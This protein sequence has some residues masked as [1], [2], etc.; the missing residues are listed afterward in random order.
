MERAFD[1]V[2]IF[3]TLG[4]VLIE[5]TGGYFMDIRISLLAVVVLL[6]TLFGFLDLTPAKPVETN[7]PSQEVAVRAPVTSAATSGTQIELVSGG[8]T[9]PA[10][11]AEPGGAGP[12]PGIVL[13]H[14]INGLDRGYVEMSDVLAEHGYAVIAIEWQTFERIPHDDVVIQIARDGIDYL[15]ANSDVDADR[16]GLTGFCIGGRYTMRFLPVIDDFASGVAWYGFPYRG[17]DA[18]ENWP[19]SPA[20]VIDQLDAP[21]LIIH[22]TADN[23]SPIADIYRYATDLDAAG[24]YFEMKIYQGEPH[25]FMLDSG[26]LSQS[27]AAQDALNEMISFFDRTLK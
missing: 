7:E 19:Q 24:K 14:S 16:V 21:M 5:F 22:G 3:G 13:L 20:E 25:S 17:A 12:H 2:R 27:F 6:M 23:P 11:I 26:N 8:Q 18:N 4:G 10:Y 9:Y 15:V 1:F